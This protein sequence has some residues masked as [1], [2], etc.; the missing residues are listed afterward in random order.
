MKSELSSDSGAVDLT[1]VLETVNA[2]QSQVSGLL[3]TL[4][5]RSRDLDAAVGEAVQRALTNAAGLRAAEKLAQIHRA[6][7]VHFARWSLGIVSTC[8]LVPTVLS[9]MLLP[10]SAQLTQARQTLQQLSAGI[11]ALS[12]E[13]GR[14]QLRYCGE[15]KRLCVRVDRKSPFYG[16]DADYMIVRGY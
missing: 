4:D 2:Q 11:A 3:E 16:E 8:A 13:G 5:S 1:R 10:S 12:R 6:T 7:G 14:T 15:T 9:W